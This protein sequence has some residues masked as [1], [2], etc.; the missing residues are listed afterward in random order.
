MIKVSEKLDTT[1]KDFDKVTTTEPAR[2]IPSRYTTGES[3]NWI[4][5]YIAS[6]IHATGKYLAY[7]ETDLEDGGMVVTIPTLKGCITEADNIEE[8]YKCI[9]DALDGWIA[10]AQQTGLKIPDPDIL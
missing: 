7:I 1:D 2:F 5:G 8:A 6:P 3:I 10:V 9:K 4:N